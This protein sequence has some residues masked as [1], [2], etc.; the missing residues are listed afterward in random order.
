MSL[1]P[2]ISFSEFQSWRNC[3][4]RWMRDY[5]DGRRA[6]VRSKYMDFGT[7][8]HEALEKYKNPDKEKKISLDEAVAVFGEKFR[9]IYITS[10]KY[11]TEAF[12]K[13]AEPKPQHKAPLTSEQVE[14]WILI[15]EKI[16]RNLHKLEELE[17]ARVLFVEHNLMEKINRTDD[18]EIKFKG[19][20][21]IVIMTKDKR[22]KSVIYIC[23]YKTCSW[24]WDQ[25]K[26]RDEE[27]Q[28]QLRLY[29]HFFCKEFNIDPKQVRCAFILLKRAS[30]N[31][32]VA[33]WL[34]VS[35]GPKTVLRAVEKLN[36]AVTGM[37]SNNYKKNRKACVNAYGDS[38]PY[39]GTDLCV[40]D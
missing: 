14:E 8:I 15:G 16:L 28:I 30:K 25:E 2:H 4:W 38:C 37:H 40:E 11:E 32:S 34:P 7:A 17:D 36:S 26:K 12:E 29:K 24:G 18:I 22:N 5:R 27:L 21:D 19:F 23:D 13:L 1:R 39:L 35:A 10:A 9:K 31:S 3:Q 20:I 33:D 6:I